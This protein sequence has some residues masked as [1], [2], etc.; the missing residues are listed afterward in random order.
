MK[1]VIRASVGDTSD[2]IPGVMGVGE[3]TAITLLGQF[4]TLD[5]IYAHLEEIPNRVR[6]KLETG[7]KSAYLSQML[8]QIR[9]DLHLTLDLEQARTDHLN[10][11]AVEILFHEL[12]FRTLTNRLL[13]LKRGYNPPLAAAANSAPGQQLSLFGEEVKRIG[14]PPAIYLQTHI[15]Q[16]EEDLVDL[17]RKLSSAPEIAFDTETTSTDPLRAA[18]VGISLAIQP[19]EACYI[20]VGHTTGEPQLPLAKVINALRPALTDPKIPKIGHNL[21]YDY[22]V[23]SEHGLNVT[24]LSFDTMLAE[25]VIDSGSHHLGLKDMADTYLNVRMTHI[26]ELIGK[27]KNQRTMAQVEIAP[28]GAYAAA[29]AEINPALE[30]YSAAAYGTGGCC[31]TVQRN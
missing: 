20:P 28:A 11:D 25:W 13:T 2:N 5:N 6:T 24:P 29:D 4:D 30:D 10:F 9:T 22:L 3:K 18:L 17:C 7:R 26:D 8:A 27:G 23:L 14:E 31:S 19:G 15:I 12:E 21:K 16:S 1:E